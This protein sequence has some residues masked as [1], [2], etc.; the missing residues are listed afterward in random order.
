MVEPKLVGGPCKAEVGPP[1]LLVKGPVECRRQSAFRHVKAAMRGP[2]D[3][4]LRQ[5]DEQSR[6]RTMGAPPLDLTVHPFGPRRI[7]RSEQDEEVRSP[8]RLL[9]GPPQAV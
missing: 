9:Y 8:E 6:G 5:R 3:L 7:R 2:H 4:A 1:R